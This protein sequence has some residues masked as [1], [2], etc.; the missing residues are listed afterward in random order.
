MENAR[1][2]ERNNQEITK[3]IQK[4]QYLTNSSH[5]KKKAESMVEKHISNK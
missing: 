4:T 2:Q 3:S 1:K 5:R